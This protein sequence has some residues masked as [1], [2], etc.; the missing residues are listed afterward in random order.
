MNSW[1]SGAY[2]RRHFLN[3]LGG[4]SAAT[5]IAVVV[6]APVAKAYDPGREE[7]RT[8]YHETEDVKAFYRTN[9]YEGRKM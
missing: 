3:A 1:P 6:P 4:A 5:V 9:R 2:D 8:R 7:T